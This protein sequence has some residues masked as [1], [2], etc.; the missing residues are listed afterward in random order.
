MNIQ[1][2]NEGDFIVAYRSG[3]H[4]VTKVDVRDNSVI[5]RQ[6]ADKNGKRIHGEKEYNCHP[7]YC[8]KVTIDVLS[9]MMREHSLI[10]DQLR[11]LSEFLP[12][13]NGGKCNIQ[14]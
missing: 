1:E 2:V 11:N 5:Y 4:I 12:K 7:I 10:I 13:A 9:E 8:H 3:F 14:E 6:V